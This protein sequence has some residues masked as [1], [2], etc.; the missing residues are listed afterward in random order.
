MTRD[1]RAKDLGEALVHYGRIFKTL[2]VPRFC[3]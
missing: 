2:H 1:G 3:W